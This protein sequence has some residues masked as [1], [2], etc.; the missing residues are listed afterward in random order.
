MILGRE[1]DFISVPSDAMEEYI[2][3]VACSNSATTTEN[4]LTDFFFIPRNYRFTSLGSDPAQ[5]SIFF[6]FGEWAIDNVWQH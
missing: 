2:P 5:D 6:H 4:N 1:A 3:V